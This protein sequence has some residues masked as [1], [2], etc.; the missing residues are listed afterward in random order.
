MYG[1]CVENVKIDCQVAA[2][3]SIARQPFATNEAIEYSVKLV[4]DCEEP[5][6]GIL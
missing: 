3:A 6:D 4:S 2:Q 5:L 1:D